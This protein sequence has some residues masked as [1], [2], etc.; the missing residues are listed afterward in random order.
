MLKLVPTY[1][2]R[3][4]APGRWVWLAAALAATA[5][6]YLPEIS[7]SWSGHVSALP[8]PTAEEPPKVNR[9]LPQVGTGRIYGIARVI[10]GDTLDIHGQ[11]IRLQGI[12][13]PEHDQTCLQDGRDWRCGAAAADALAREI[14]RRPVSCESHGKDKY[15]RTVA[16]CSVGTTG[17]NSWMA[18][19]GWAVAA[20]GYGEGYA[21]SAQ[22]AQADR[23]GIWA[24]EFALPAEWR[25]QR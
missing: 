25:R 14:G 13:A 3:R 17:L 20:N 12:D 10:D 9:K 23:L 5:F 2:R 8:F 6:F 24:S 22:Q 4:R 18:R 7:A 21:E 1:R 11:R 16:V 15:R 19:Q